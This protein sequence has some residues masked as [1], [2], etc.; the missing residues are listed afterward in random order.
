MP[1]NQTKPTNQSNPKRFHLK[2]WQWVSVLAVVAVAV[3]I[4]GGVFVVWESKMQ[5]SMKP[6]PKVISKY[7]KLLDLDYNQD[8]EIILKLETFKDELPLRIYLDSTSDRIKDPLQECHLILKEKGVYNLEAYC[9]LGMRGDPLQSVY[10]LKI[11]DLEKEHK[12][13]ICANYGCEERILQPQM[14]NK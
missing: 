10:A 2:T 14:N 13:K 11:D 12:I 9:N 1:N 6:E 5:V 8:G 3:V 7:F 4:A